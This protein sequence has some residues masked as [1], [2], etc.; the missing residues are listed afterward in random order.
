MQQWEDGYDHKDLGCWNSS[1][2]NTLDFKEDDLLLPSWNN[3]L[4]EEDGSKETLLHIRDEDSVLHD[5]ILLDLSFNESIE[6]SSMEEKIQDGSELPDKNDE[7]MMDSEGLCEDSRDDSCGAEEDYSVGNTS[8]SVE[9]HWPVSPF[10]CKSD[11]VEYKGLALVHLLIVCAEAISDGSHDLVEVILSRLKELVSSTGATMERVAYYLSQSL[12]QRHHCSIAGDDMEEDLFNAFKSTKDPNYLGALTL[13][14][15]AYPYIR[16]AHFIAN[17]SILEAIPVQ[18]AKTLHIL[19]FDIMEGMQWPPLIEALKSEA[20]KICHLKLTA[21]KWD[22]DDDDDD[23]DDGD[24][25]GDGNG[26]G[27]NGG[28]LGQFSL[29]CKDTGRRLSEYACSLGIPFSFQETQLENLKDNLSCSDDEMVVVNCMWALPHMLERSSKKLSRFVEGTC[30]LNPAILTLGTG[31]NGIL[32]HKKVNLLE[33]FVRCLKNSC[34]LFDSMEAGLPEQYGSAR[35]TM[36]RL[37]MAPMICRPIHYLSEDEEFI[38]V[39]DLPLQYGFAEGH[40]SNKNTM[41][42][43]LMAEEGEHYRMEIEGNN[44]LLLQW[45]SIPLTSISTWKPTNLA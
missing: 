5:E 25:D 9:C 2:I 43:K 42:A 1:F 39:M 30:H 15:Q 36:E 18:Q 44:Q 17:Q 27:G 10:L 21:V 7:T 8:G 37:F 4:F 31:P 6:F 35:A 19:D 12:E 41:N 40:I 28:D 23:D 16:F 45:Q 13:L 38:R 33:R 3:L 22:D 32:G 24:G 20:H 29:S 14:N 11:S 34:A 26:N